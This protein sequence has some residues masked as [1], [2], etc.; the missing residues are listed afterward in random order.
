MARR[1]L[2]AEAVADLLLESDSEGDFVPDDSG[3]EYV[4]S[5]SSS[6]EKSSSG[7]EEEP[8]DIEPEPLPEQGIV[9]GPEPR[10]G[11]FPP[12]YY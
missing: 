4:P 6:S 9:G 12:L 3:S 11:R 7:E 2:S 1:Q 5:D 10:G 8:M